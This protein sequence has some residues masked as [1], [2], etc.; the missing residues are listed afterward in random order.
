[1][2]FE[3]LQTT[4]TIQGTRVP[5]LPK[6]VVARGYEAQ[7]RTHPVVAWA[8]V[9]FNPL[10]V[11]I[12]HLT[13]KPI[14]YW[15]DAPFET[16]RSLYPA[17][18]P[19]ALKTVQHAHEIDTRLVRRSVLAGY[20]SKW[21]ADG[22]LQ[23]FPRHRISLSFHTEQTSKILLIKTGSQRKYQ[24]DR[25]TKPFLFSLSEWTS[26]AKA[27]RLLSKSWLLFGLVGSMHR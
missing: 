4:R 14:A 24:I 11:S 7:L 1:M 20:S 12:S 6:S 13:S 9:V 27:G 22:A 23:L 10:G 18:R 3:T 16:L 21:A 17:L 19:Y 8:D 5:T 26:C 25:L 2:G 15:A